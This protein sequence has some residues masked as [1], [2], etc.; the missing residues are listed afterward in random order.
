[1]SLLGSSRDAVHWCPSADGMVHD[2][3]QEERGWFRLG[4]GAMLGHEALQYDGAREGKPPP[5]CLGSDRLPLPG[6]E[7]QGGWA[8]PRVEEL[9]GEMRGAGS[10]WPTQ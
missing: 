6:F 2:D 3:C 9:I 1:M 7:N 5:P 10:M 8:V 4:F